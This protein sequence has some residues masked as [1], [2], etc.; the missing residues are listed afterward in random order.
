MNDFSAS[1]PSPRLELLATICVDGVD[2]RTFLQGQL[3]FDMD[4]L[5]PQRAEL[6]CCNSAQG[7]VQAITWLIQRSDG[8]VLLLPASMVDATIARL[9]KYIL[10]AKVKIES[11]AQRLAAYAVDSHPANYDAR[12]H[13]ESGPVSY[14]GWPSASEAGKPGRTLMLAPPTESATDA[15]ATQAWHLADLRA[16]LPQIYPQTHELFVAQMLNLDLLGAISF[17]KGCY[18]GQEII[19]RTHYRG[20]IKRRMFRFIANCPPPSPAMRIVADGAHAGDVVDSAATPEGC[21]FLAVLNLAQLDK[22]LRLD[23]EPGVE[24][25]REKMTYEVTSEG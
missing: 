20:S 24:L 3:S 5:T 2:A 15:V 6:A 16:G 12:Q 1:V 17:D 19:A 7:R 25:R 23:E 4:R 18:T 22:A 14:I 11:G 21:E 9:R 13:I 10:R 8:V